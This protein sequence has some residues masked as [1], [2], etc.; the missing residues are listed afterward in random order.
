MEQKV[1]LFLDV[2]DYPESSELIDTIM[3]LTKNDED[4]LKYYRILNG[5]NHKP[6][7]FTRKDK[8]KILKNVSFKISF[9]KDQ[10]H[11]VI[12]FNPDNLE[13]PF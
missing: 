4:V 10:V 9:T 3:S 6:S 12:I 11:I 5:I 2:K 1:E 8:N 7:F 13:L